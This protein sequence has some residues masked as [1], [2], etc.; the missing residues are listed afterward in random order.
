MVFSQPTFLFL[1]L[2]IVLGLYALA[3]R[4]GKNVLL[5]A[6]SL[7]FYS[8][9]ESWLVIVMLVSIG[10]NY[11]FGRRLEALGAS[12]GVAAPS[13]DK[14]GAADP[15]EQANLR[16]RRRV[17]ALAVAFNL[18]LLIAL[19]YAV[20]LLNVFAEPIRSLGFDF[21]PPESMPPP[22]GI[23]FFTFQAISYVVDVYRGQA[24]AQRRVLDFA[25]YI[26]LFPQLIAGPI[27]RYRDIA[28]QIQSRSTGLSDFAE[29]SRRFVF[30]LAKKVVIADTM[31]SFSTTIF[32]I[33]GDEITM[34]LAWVG[35]LFY[36]L[37]LYFDFSGYS[38]MA[39][40]LGRMFG[41]RLLENFNYPYLSTSVADF[42][43]RW[44]IS[45]ST[46]FR[47]YLY[48]PMGG[49]RKGAVRTYLH[50]MTVF[51]LCGLWHGAAGIYI[52]FGLYHGALLILERV[53]VGRALERSPRPF[54]HAYALLAIVM[55]FT[56]FR[57]TSLSEALEYAVPLFSPGIG[58]SLRHPL[59]LYVDSKALIIAGLGVLLSTPV[60]PAFL[61]WRGRASAVLGG[62]SDLV[63]IGVLGA[64]VVATGMF[65][66]VNTF[67]PFLYFRF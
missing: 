50:L 55:G 56:V 20:W 44:H 65:L 45:L 59:A 17:V 33:P 60:Y 19:K 26:A 7:L 25:L 13:L 52:V 37:H 29:G 40:G 22:I 6:A 54:R 12:E 35:L 16:Q 14:T 36:S 15:V 62:A 30:G 27:V 34:P 3:P 61:R 66:S 47:D 43:R 67:T 24:Q 18:A 10:A 63:E 41:F 9:G 21:Q 38:D 32:A 2:P 23:S 8:W 39:I 57:A 49:N 31:S 5:L 42:W 4:R 11:R 64:A 1:F 53:G 48:V 51:V 58:D 46:W 28:Q